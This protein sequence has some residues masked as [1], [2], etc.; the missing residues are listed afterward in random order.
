MV[1]FD[2]DTSGAGREVV[3]FIVDFEGKIELF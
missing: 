3:G 1:V 2:Q